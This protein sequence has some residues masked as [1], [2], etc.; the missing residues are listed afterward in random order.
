MACEMWIDGNI[1]R[2]ERKLDNGVL[3]AVDKNICLINNVGHIHCWHS[4]LR[5]ATEGKI[6]VKKPQRRQRMKMPDWTQAE[7]NE[8]YSNKYSTL[9]QKSTGTIY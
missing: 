7:E 5:R 2:T 9:K 6:K 8:N 1:S 3:S 4:V